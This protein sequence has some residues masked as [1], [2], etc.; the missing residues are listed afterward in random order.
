M[1]VA[2]EQFKKLEDAASAFEKAIELDHEYLSFHRELVNFHLRHNHTDRAKSAFARMLKSVKDVNAVFE[3]FRDEEDGYQ[4][5]YAAS[6]E[7]LLLAFTKEME[8]SALGWTLLAEL[9]YAQKK[10]GAA[11]KS[12]QRALAIKPS[13]DSF[14]YLSMLYRS[15]RRYAESLSAADQAVKLEAESVAAHFERAC[16]LARLGRKNEAMK[17]L[18]RVFEIDPDTYFDTEEAD[19]QSLSAIPEFQTMKEKIDKP[20]A[21]TK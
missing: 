11:I 6:L 12:I 2:H 20:G 10:A 9:Q 18:N 5:E 1:A 21:T 17:A 7:S 4:P 19:L 16:S 13:A 3:Y 15:E 8:G 14:V